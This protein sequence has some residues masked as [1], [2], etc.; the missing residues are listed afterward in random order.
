MKRIWTMGAVVATAALAVLGAG[1]AHAQG[2]GAACDD[3]LKSLFHPDAE[4]R[5]VAVKAFH[6]GDSLVGG[7]RPPPPFSPVGWPAPQLQATSDLCLVKLMVG[8]GNPGPA[9]APSTSEG[10]GI[11]IWL[12]SAANWNHRMHV[13]GGGGWQGGFAGA[14]DTIADFWAAGIASVE[15]AVSSTTDTGHTAPSGAVM[16][17][18][19]GSINQALWA[20]FASRA[21]HVQAVE[22]K[23]LAKLY[24]G[25]APKYA[26]WEGGSTGG[27]QGLNLAQNH[28][29]DFDGIIALY[30]AVH[31]TRFITGELYPQIVTQRD[32]GGHG[33]TVTQLN[34]ASNA[35]IAACDQVGGQHL[36]YIPDPSVC[37]YDPVADATVLCAAD[38]GTNQTPD[39]LSK[40]RA[41]AVDKIWYGMTRD[42]SVPS[43]SIDNGWKAASGVRFPDGL[44]TSFGLARGS[45]LAA[46]ANPDFP[47]SIGADVVALELESP[48]IGSPDFH[49]ATGAGQSGWKALSYADMARAYDRGVA[50]QPAFGGINTENPDLSAFKRHGG[51]LLTWHGLADQLIPPQG[52]IEY[53]N[54]VADRMGGLAQ[55]QSFYRLYLAPGLG[56]GSPNGTSNP[57]AA[58]P[59]FST[60]QMY[61]LITAWVEQGRAPEDVVLTSTADGHAKSR[62]VCVYPKKARY[63]GGDAN[64]AASYAC[65]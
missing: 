38:G 8:P 32:L 55:V 50:L 43:P 41:L 14:P 39:C 48:A 36:G 29:D 20:D 31:W 7:Q 13:L 60:G 9:G 46:L 62:P 42:G 4:T 30:P 5:V 56:H 33:L 6:K 49:N 18:P 22:T 63:L 64:I 54:S 25:E 2:R 26:Y 44:Q 3:S 51:K 17:K 40:A 45:T 37:A 16:M 47:F 24:Y 27:R 59:V 34:L 19:D 61:G 57:T 12:P 10:I 53:Y 15:G 35:A 1:G 58:P 65:G 28:P 52:T 11:E 23:A 21:I